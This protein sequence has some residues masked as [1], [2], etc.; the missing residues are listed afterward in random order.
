MW[1]FRLL[2]VLE[3]KIV[4]GRMHLETRIASL[5]DDVYSHYQEVKVK[6]S[7][8]RR[9]CID[10]QLFDTSSKAESHCEKKMKDQPSRHTQKN[11]HSLECSGSPRGQ[12][13]L[14]RWNP[15][16]ACRPIVDEAPVFYPTEEEFQ[17]T[18]GYIATIRPKAESY[19]ICR[20]V[21][22]PSWIPPC[23]LKD[24][25]VW[26]NAK[27][28]TRIQQVNLLQNREPMR[29][30]NRGRKRKR[31]R[32]SRMGSSRRHPGS[33]GSEGNTTSDTEEKFGFQPGSDFTLDDFQKF[34]NY[35]KECYFGMKNEKDYSNVDET[36]HKFWELSVEDIEGEYWRIIEQP[37]DE[38]EVYYGADLET[39][40]FGSGFPKASSLL[41][42]KSESD[43]YEF[44]CHGSMLGCASHHFV[45]MLRTTIS[46]HLTIYTGVN[47]K[48]GME[49]LEAMLLH[50]RMRMRKHLPDLFHEQPDLLNELVTQLSP[51]VLKSEGVPIYRAIQHSGEFVLTFP[52]AYHSGFNCGFNCAE[53]VNVAPVDWLKHGQSAVEFY[54][55][56]CRKTSLSHDKL[57]LGSAREAIQALWQLSV[58]KKENLRNLSWKSVC[59]K[60]G[61]LTKAVKA[62]VQIEQE[63]IENLPT[64][65]RFQKMEKDFDLK[66]EREC[67]SCFYDLHLSAACCKC[68]TDRFA[69][70]KHANLVC[71]CELGNRFV[72]LRY[73]MD[74]LNTLVEVLE[75]KLDAMRSWVA[76]DLGLVPL[77]HKDSSFAKMDQD[78]EASGINC[79]KQNGSSSRSP[80]TAESYNINEPCSLTHCHVSP[81]VQS[82]TQ[83][84]AFS[85]CASDCMTDEGKVGQECCI[86]LNLDSISGERGSGLQQISDSCDNK[87]IVNMAETC[88]SLCVQENIY[89]SDAQREPDIMRLSNECDSSVSH[90]LS[91]KDHPS[92]L[93]DVAICCATDGNK[94]F[95]VDLLDHQH[96]SV[97]LNN[98][99]KSEI[100]DVS[101]VKVSLTDKSGPV[102]KLSF[103]VDPINYGS[104]VFG[105]LWCNKQAIFPKGF[106]SR[107]KFFNVLDPRKMSS[108]VSEI[109][110]AGF[111]GPLFKVTLEDCPSESFANVS[112]EWCWEMVLQR[113]N[114]EITRQSSLGKQGL[115][116][117]QSPQSINGLEMFGFLS[118]P[119]IQA[120]EALDPSHQCIEYWNHKLTF[121]VKHLKNFETPVTSTNASNVENCPFV[122]S[123][124]VGK[125][126]PVIFG[127]NLT[128]QEDTSV[129][130][131]GNYSVDEELRTT[132]RGLLKKA[133]PEELK[134]MQR[135]LCSESSSPEWRVAL[136]TLTEEIQRTCK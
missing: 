98:L 28:S 108:Y 105:K 129:I 20:I 92:C 64:H 24:N 113:L 127:Y 27:F 36:E 32:H 1:I 39:G 70:L 54:S 30:K 56:Q 126:E 79:L 94:L 42:G 57:L 132:L 55:E 60:D 71:S 29:K 46:T 117:L 26:E 76:E 10:Y 16:K 130:G 96:L 119:I 112:A 15:D 102:Q 74:E 21:P 13:I 114:Q 12:K 106:R 122:S 123:C 78:R 40:A 65:L 80:R 83:Q 17:D 23:P 128:K 75:G 45:G 37:T 104:V 43:Q 136:T 86:D 41:T 3:S 22:P 44:L 111:L 91:N 18:L 73:T 47:Q 52:R 99:S 133:N 50:W 11:D 2:A 110:D 84:G 34:A 124:S 93:M 49:F 125:T 82:D 58:L 61:I 25:I 19:G 68:S 103:C 116:P 107:V 89:N 100:V 63:R 59:G 31:R 9:N 81:V 8:R 85:L 88:I 97:P 51:S 77:N 6:R 5:K 53:A 7:L 69:C 120:I 135:I 101:D 33:E 121:N 67:F 48:Y 90:V 115:P 14:A 35:F 72:L 66:S 62:R 38:V 134:I 131:S 118:T 87:V 4:G 95:G 109:L